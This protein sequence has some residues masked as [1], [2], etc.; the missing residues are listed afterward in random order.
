MVPVT[1]MGIV[2][3]MPVIVIAIVV[4]P[5]VGSPGPP[6]SRVVS[7]VPGGP[8]YHISRTVDVPDHRP[9]SYIIIGG[10]DHID[11]VPVDFSGVTR[12]RRFC[13]DR[14]DDII[15]T[16]KCLIPDQLYLHSTVGHLL[17][18]ENGH[19]LLLIPVKSSP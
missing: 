16:V 3:V 1:I 17:H 14:F 15:G 8:P 4:V 12:I 11:I 9:G 6:V 7:P 19:I 18:D 5:V 10:S 2:M 13:I